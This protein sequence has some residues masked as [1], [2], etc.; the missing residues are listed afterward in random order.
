MNANSDIES[1]YNSTGRLAIEKKPK[2]VTCREVFCCRERFNSLR[3]GILDKAKIVYVDTIIQS[4][5]D[6]EEGEEEQEERK[7]F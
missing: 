7:T 4:E 2:R 5:S 3:K 6:A 1:A